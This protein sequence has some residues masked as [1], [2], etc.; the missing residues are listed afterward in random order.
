VAATV[1]ENALPRDVLY[2]NYAASVLPLR[3]YGWS[4]AGID[5]RVFAKTNEEPW[6]RGNAWP[7]V[8][9]QAVAGGVLQE[10][11]QGK[12]VW[13]LSYGSH[14]D[15]IT[16]GIAAKPVRALHRRTGK[17]DLSLFQP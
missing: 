2:V 7:V 17:L 14:P 16:D 5:I 4:D 8:A 10:H 11:R 13:L 1:R 3:H 6:F 12:R 9:P 15:Q